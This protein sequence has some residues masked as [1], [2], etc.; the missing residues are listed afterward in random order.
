M[1]TACI[2]E[3]KRAESIHLMF[4]WY[5]HAYICVI[6]FS[7]PCYSIF[8]GDRWFTRGWTLQ[9]A[10]A[11]TRIGC[12]ASDWHR[13]VESG[14]KID[15]YRDPDTYHSSGLTP[16]HVDGPIF[17]EFRDE[18]HYGEWQEYEP[19]VEQAFSVFFSMRN[20][21]TTLP[22]DAVYCILSALNVSIP[23]EY[24]TTI[25]SAG[26]A[27]AFE[28]AFYRLLVELLTRGSDCRLFVTPKGTSSRY[29]SLLPRSYSDCG[30]DFDYSCRE[31]PAATGIS[32][33]SDHV[34]KNRLSLNPWPLAAVAS[35]PPKLPPHETT[36]IM[37]AVL[38]MDNSDL[39]GALLR[40]VALSPHQAPPPNI[41]WATR[42]QPQ[43]KRHH[44]EMGGIQR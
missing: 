18:L 7:T 24:D 44:R 43:G 38:G 31:H 11:S 29:N 28:K 20:R 39:C 40:P 32:F 12:F 36:G 2:D 5:R 21:K 10:L 6:Q 8:R 14:R 1:D 27:A 26:A 23:V 41:Q 19:G 33:D 9:E 34:M 25:D 22:V 15:I 16:N 35:A 4:E 17:H 37:F 3:E 30:W 42:R 13:I